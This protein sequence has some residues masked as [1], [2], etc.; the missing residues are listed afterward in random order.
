MTD[1]GIVSNYTYVPPF[2]LFLNAW[3]VG[4]PKLSSTTLLMTTIALFSL[5]L[6]SF[7]CFFRC[8]IRKKVSFTILLK[9][10]CEHPK[11]KKKVSHPLSPLHSPR[12]F[13]IRPQ[14]DRTGEELEVLMNWSP[15]FSPT[16][17]FFCFN[18]EGS[19]PSLCIIVTRDCTKPLLYF[20]FS[21]PWNYFTQGTHTRA[22]ISSRSFDSSCL[23][24]IHNRLLFSS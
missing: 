23:V 18:W 5:S 13:L 16:H 17:F 4:D 21:F 8:C 7:F 3:I 22:G 10:G 24:V 6:I 9:C 19:D 14:A 12:L 15:L 20:P 2:S 11:K 1:R